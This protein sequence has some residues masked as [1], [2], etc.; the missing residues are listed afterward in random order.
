M[1]FCVSPLIVSPHK[2]CSAAKKMWTILPST[3]SKLGVFLITLNILHWLF[4]PQ[5]TQYV[6]NILLLADK[7]RVSLTHFKTLQ[8][9]L[10]GKC[11]N[12]SLYIIFL[13]FCCVQTVDMNFIFR[14]IFWQYAR[15]LLYFCVQWNVILPITDLLGTSTLGNFQR[16]LQWHLL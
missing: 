13:F 3:N 4:L 11:S 16:N 5:T 1:W 15:L 7:L 6:L 10:V 12:D 14:H 9:A 8:K 2:P